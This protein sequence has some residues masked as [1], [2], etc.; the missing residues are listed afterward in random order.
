MIFCQTH[1]YKCSRFHVIVSHTTSHVLFR[2]VNRLIIDTCRFL[3]RSVAGNDFSFHG[4]F[5]FME[6]LVDV[7]VLIAVCTYIDRYTLVTALGVFLATNDGP[8]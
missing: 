5:P 4:D 8:K 6:N 2:E 3:C 7:C 1:N